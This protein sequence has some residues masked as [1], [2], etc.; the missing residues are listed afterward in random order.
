MKE[1][2]QEWSNLSEEGREPYNKLAAEG[3]PKAFPFIPYRFRF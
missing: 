2:G 1:F 3:K